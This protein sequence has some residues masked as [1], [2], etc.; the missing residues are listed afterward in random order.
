MVSVKVHFLNHTSLPRTFL[1][2]VSSFSATDREALATRHACSCLSALL[3]SALFY[4]Q[5]RNSLGG[6]IKVSDSASTHSN[7]TC[8]QYGVRP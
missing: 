5:T 7:Y 6:W 2:T 4:G 1:T 3:S 8:I